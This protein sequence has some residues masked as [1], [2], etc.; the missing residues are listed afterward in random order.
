MDQ[1]RLCF[2]KS[3][4]AL[5]REIQMYRSIWLGTHCTGARGSPGLNTLLVAGNIFF[6]C[7]KRVSLEVLFF[8]GKKADF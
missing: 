3:G 4:F 1:K 6:P 8:E 7:G 5:Q 2:T